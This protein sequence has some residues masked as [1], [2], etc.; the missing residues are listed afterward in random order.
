VLA[1]FDIPCLSELEAKRFF[2]PALMLMKDRFVTE[3]LK[4][5]AM[6][7]GG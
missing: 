4:S 2:F 3:I 7:D 5:R 1:S 6:S